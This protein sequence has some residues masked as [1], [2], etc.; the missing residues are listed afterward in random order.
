MEDIT[1]LFGLFDQG[2]DSRHFPLQS[3]ELRG[4]HG[5]PGVEDDIDI[6]R[7]Q[8]QIPAHGFAHAP[9]DAVTLDCFA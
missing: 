8:S 5:S 7:Q 1:L 9:F 3:V 2:E 6:P 4:Q